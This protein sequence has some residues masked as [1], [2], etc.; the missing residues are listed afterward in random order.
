MILAIGDKSSKRDYLGIVAPSTVQAEISFNLVGDSVVVADCYL[1]EAFPRLLG[2]PIPHDVRHHC[3][4]QI[5]RPSNHSLISKIYGQLI[6]LSTVVVVFVDDLGGMNAAAEEIAQWI[7]DTKEFGITPCADLLLATGQTL[8]ELRLDELLVDHVLQHL[9][10]RDL[11]RTPTYVEAKK[12]LRSCFGSI[13][14][15]RLTAGRRVLPRALAASHHI[16]AQRHLV[17]HTFSSTLF[18]HIFQTALQHL[19]DDSPFHILQ[20]YPPVSQ[21]LCFPLEI[22][23]RR[24][25]ARKI[26]PFRAIASAL[27]IEIARVGTPSV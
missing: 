4:N 8:P 16:F 5:S 14:R 3:L 26:R 24:L 19:L 6:P 13:A 15:V 11:M 20:A 9:R 22:V 18:S 12:K 25:A 17:R 1:Q 23:C 10:T 27:A 21:E 7:C 2:G